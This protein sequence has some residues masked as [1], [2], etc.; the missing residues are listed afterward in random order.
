VTTPLTTELRGLPLLSG[1]TD[2]E[3]E[4]LRG[5]GAR[6]TAA[7]GS[8]LVRQGER[9]DS[10]YLVLSGT[11]RV[12]MDGGEIAPLV[13]T[14]EC[15]GELAV[16]DDTP[17]TATVV[18]AEEM[19]LL[20]FPAEVFRTAL[21]EIP[22]LRDAV[23]RALVR[24]LRRA[25]SAWAQ[26]AVDTDVLLEAYY[27]IQGTGEAGD[28]HAAVTAAAELI[29]RLAS[30]TEQEDAVPGPALTTL[31]P[32]ERRVADLV[33]GGLSNA[34]V[35]EELSVS[36]HTVASHLKHIYTKLGISS[37][38]ALAAAVLKGAH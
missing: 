24:R 18:A 8:V 31:T 30:G 22:A 16:L 1:L 28:R 9:A 33:A 37:R 25:S 29:R 4:R 7:A 3:V 21:A 27:E 38:V 34:A 2:A 26:I 10:V 5:M 19:D 20:V 11:A 17:R 36:E 12:V 35:A 6:L 15:I 14:G 13:T 23:T 32:A